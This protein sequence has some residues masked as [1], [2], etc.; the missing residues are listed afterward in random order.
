MDA[1]CTIPLRDEC[2]DGHSIWKGHRRTTVNCT[3]W[4]RILHLRIVA[5]AL[6]LKNV[7]ENAV[8][9]LSQFHDASRM[10]EIVHVGPPT[11]QVCNLE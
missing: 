7:E 8:R 5:K 3:Y 6:R 1:P 9:P 11:P 4:S 10:S 2:I